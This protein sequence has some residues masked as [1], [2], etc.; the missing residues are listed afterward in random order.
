[1]KAIYKK[2]VHFS[3]SCEVLER[4]DD[5]VKIANKSTA[6]PGVITRSDILETIILK[7]TRNKLEVIDEQIRNHAIE[8]NRLQDLKRDIET[9][10]LNKNIPIQT[11]KE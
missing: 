6:R 9:K 3:I 1:M 5:L 2:R 10:A 8:I 11:I 7:N 4:L